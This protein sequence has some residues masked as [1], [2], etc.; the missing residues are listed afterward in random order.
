MRRTDLVLL[1]LVLAGAVPGAVR[2]A[3]DAPPKGEQVKS[4]DH[5]LDLPLGLQ[6]SAAYV[7]EDNPLSAA[8]IELGRLLY[9]DKRLSQ[10][11]TVSCATC[12]D[13]AHGFA[14]PR[15]TSSGVA[16]KGGARNAPTVSNR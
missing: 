1:M 14:E 7:P 12:H 8:K 15:K 3:G 13:P 4:G 6:A 5:T 2:A 16:G 9:F 11:D 10:D